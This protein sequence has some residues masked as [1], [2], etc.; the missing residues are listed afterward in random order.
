MWG[1]R[2]VVP[3]FHV[4]LENMGRLIGLLCKALPDGWE[5]D[6]PAEYYFREKDPNLVFIFVKEWA[7]PS[8]EPHVTIKRTGRDEWQASE[9]T[10]HQGKWFS[11]EECAAELKEFETALYAAASKIGSAVEF[12]SE[13]PQSGRVLKSTAAG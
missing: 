11:D 1:N 12:V 3:T 10:I 5:R 13:H 2:S 8:H 9:V 7:A 4:S 6:R